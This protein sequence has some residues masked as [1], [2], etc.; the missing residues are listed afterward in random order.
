MR[1]TYLEPLLAPFE[2]LADPLRFQNGRLGFEAIRLHERGKPAAIH[3]AYDFD[4]NALAPFLVRP[5]NTFA[6]DFPLLMGI[7]NVTPDSFS[8]G[9]AYI[10][11]EKALE[12]AS[13]LAALGASILDF[14]AE[15][16][17]PGAEFVSSEEE[18]SRLMPIFDE[19]PNIQTPISID[20]RKHEVA[21]EAIGAGAQMINDV[22]ALQ[23]DEHMA[24][25]LARS[26]VALCLMHAQGDPKTMQQN[27]SYDHPI[28]DIF[29]HLE[30]RIQFAE[31]H[32]IDRNRITI[33]PGIGFGK[34]LEHNLAILRH[35]PLF[36]AL[37]CPI[38]LGA[39]RKSMIDKIH[40]S[41]P[42]AR[43][44]GSLAIA[45]D[46]AQKGVQIL[47]VHDV[48]ETQQALRIQDRI[49]RSTGIDPSA[50]QQD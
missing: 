7:I 33:D 47:R 19:M 9:G 15:S 29:D 8:D 10:Q 48:E 26:D 34:T 28:L 41:D 3:S 12:H 23:F 36:H 38:L 31:A 1:E 25:S 16:T 24:P 46:A 14:G 2:D 20:T 49:N 43:L 4:D 44:G 50:N 22:S 37:S 27:P 18:I 35:L 13:Q 5:K 30:E 11:G 21:L 17:R 32:G 42:D 40:P 39:S 45:L 6:S